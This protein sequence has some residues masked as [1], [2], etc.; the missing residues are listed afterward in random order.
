M[1]HDRA[2]TTELTF[3]RQRFTCDRGDLLTQPVPQRG[4]P[5]SFLLLAFACTRAHVETCGYDSYE[6]Q[7]V[8]RLLTAILLTAI[9][10][11]YPTTHLF[12][13]ASAWPYVALQDLA[14][15][16]YFCSY[17]SAL[18]LSGSDAEVVPSFAFDTLYRSYGYIL[19]H[20]NCFEE[21]L[22]CFRIFSFFINIDD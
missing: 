3:Q 12:T 18:A 8:G 6:R 5:H 20:A 11:T 19:Y 17:F 21:E 14:E 13:P 9:L 4:Y 1:Q 15:A 2:D 10:L 16:T 7:C 22:F